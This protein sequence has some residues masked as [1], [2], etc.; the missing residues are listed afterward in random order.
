MRIRTL[1]LTLLLLGL[2]VALRPALVRAEPRDT[3]KAEAR[4]NDG[5]RAAEPKEA[6]TTEGESYWIGVQCAPI[7]DPALRAQLGLER[8][9]GLLVDDVLSGSPA[10]KAG[11]ERYDVLVAVGDH[12]LRDVQALHRAI[13][14]AGGGEVTIEFYRAGRKQTLAVKPSKRSGITPQEA[15]QWWLGARPNMPGES[16][17]PVPWVKPGYPQ[18]PQSMFFVG[19]GMVMPQNQPLPEGMSVTI[20]RQGREPAKVT[21][22]QGDK[23]WETTEDKL[24]E[25]PPDIRREVEK[26]LPRFPQFNIGAD[27]GFVQP[28]PS[29]RLPAGMNPNLDRQM[30]E[31]NAQIEQLRKRLDRLERANAKADD[32]R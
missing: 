9:E 7:D 31:M 1:P 10:A 15:L 14:G 16:V 26:L 3:S 22:K 4:E 8:H 25:L 5:D 24:A 12:R 23:T 27:A 11:L 29:T 28:A 19:P 21:V 20:V 13:N 6:R 32:S 17:P 30:G 2:A 18:L